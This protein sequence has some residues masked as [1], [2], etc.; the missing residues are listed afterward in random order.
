MSQRKRKKKPS[1]YSKMKK[2]AKRAESKLDTIP[3]VGYKE[4]ANEWW[5]YA[6]GIIRSKIFR[7][8]MLISASFLMMGSGVVEVQRSR[9]A[10][11]QEMAMRVSPSNEPSAFS[12]SNV[13]VTFKPQFRSDDTYIVPFEIKELEN[14]SLNPD[15]YIIQLQGSNEMSDID[16]SARMVLFG[17]SGRGAV[18]M[19][20]EYTGEPLNIY[21][22]STNSLMSTSGERVEV[23]SDQITQMQAEQGNLI[24]NHQADGTTNEEQ[25]TDVATGSIMVGGQ[26]MIVALDMVATRLN[27]SAENVTP[28]YRAVT[29][30]STLAE[31]YDVTF[32][33]VDRSATLTNKESAEAQ[34]DDVVDMIEEYNRRL[35]DDPNITGA[36]AEKIKEANR[37]AVAN[38][39]EP[40]INLRIEQIL[41]DT[42]VYADQNVSDATSDNA[43]LS[44]M[45]EEQRREFLRNKIDKESIGISQQ[46]STLEALDTL[47]VTVSDLNYQIAL[48]DAELEYIDQV[49]AEQDEMGRSSV[50]YEILTPFG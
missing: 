11:A 16:M 15:D 26:E 39:G 6:K 21:M 36:D 38:M 2:V 50:R 14:L 47:R 44:E 35:S 48:Y 32:G 20:G 5:R 27:P 18:L 42:D 33:A 49:S 10:S 12:L 23:T 13:E 46:T 1:K 17:T 7:R 31:L 28:T 19:E 4:R 22:I 37:L 40:E 43:P 29:I 3:R 30:N 9:A 8:T 41:M 25:D 45:T 24:I 34:R